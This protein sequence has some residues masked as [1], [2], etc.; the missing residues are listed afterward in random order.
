MFTKIAAFKFEEHTHRYP[1]LVYN[2]INK[3][4]MTEY[5][6]HKTNSLR[7]Y[8]FNLFPMCPSILMPEYDTSKI[9]I[10]ISI[11]FKKKKSHESKFFIYIERNNLPTVSGY[12][13]FVTSGC[14]L[15]I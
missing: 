5:C 11:F 12:T 15:F 4:G 7:E 9:L 13:C 14:S 3:T 8:F 2:V 1:Y 10:R 6:Q